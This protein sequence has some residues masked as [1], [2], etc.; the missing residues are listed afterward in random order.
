MI[1]NNKVYPS[2]KDGLN[3]NL[4]VNFPL[5]ILDILALTTTSNRNWPIPNP[6]STQS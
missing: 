6:S 1:K 3:P 4:D 5:V 2:D